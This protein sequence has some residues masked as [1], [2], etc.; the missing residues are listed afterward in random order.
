MDRTVNMVLSVVLEYCSTNLRNLFP[1]H[2]VEDHHQK[3]CFSTPLV[4]LHWTVVIVCFGLAPINVLYCSRFCVQGTVALPG[5]RYLS[6][7]YY[8]YISCT[9]QS[10]KATD[11]LIHIV[12]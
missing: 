9:I 8:S 1:V 7:Y 3:Q 2:V 4:L 12:L 6:C 11:I 10:K 5:Y